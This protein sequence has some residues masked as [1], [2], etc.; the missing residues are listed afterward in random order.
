MAATARALA[1]SLLLSLLPAALPAAQT[2]PADDTFQDEITVALRTLTVRVVD[3]FGRPILGLTPRDFRVRL[4]GREVPVV[5]VDWIES[6][7]AVP[8]SQTVAPGL[9]TT[10]EEEPRAPGKLVVFFVQADLN[11]TRISGQLRLR[12]YVRELLDTLRPEDRAA[13]VSFDSHLHFRQDFTGDWDAV[14]A[15]IDRGMLWGGEDEDAEGEPV[16]LL[17]HFDADGALRAAS[18]ERALGVTARA[19]EP[20]QGEKVIV[21]LGWG[22]GTFSSFGVQMTPDFAPAVRAL[23]RAHASVFVLD[24]TSADSHSLETGLQTV[25]EATGGT[26]AKTFVLPGLATRA[27][28]RTISG[29]YVLTVDPGD[30]PPGGGTLQIRLRHRS[31][32][33][34]AR[35]V[36]VR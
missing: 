9:S 26:Y 4:R 36:A 25:A 31:G 5:G 6:G 35:P 34:V 1:L 32:N 19:L 10:S 21:F 28:A 13:V 14:H 2:P 30:L 23:K 17:R 3:D 22:L 15:A 29:Y 11:P 7:V 18:P 27:L 16:S 33:V 12:P 20:I 8:P 24:V